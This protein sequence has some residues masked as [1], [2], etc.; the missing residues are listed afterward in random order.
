MYYYICDYG[1]RDFQIRVRRCGIKFQVWCL[2]AVRYLN[3][4]NLNLPTFL[5]LKFSIGL[6]IKRVVSIHSCSPSFLSYLL[7]KQQS[8]NYLDCYASSEAS[9][10]LALNLVR[11]YSSDSDSQIL[12]ACL[13]FS[14]VNVI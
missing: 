4:L 11:F 12:K 3:S 10:G 5:L 7:K 14:S 2:L 8:P 9:R 1:E 6:F 13:G